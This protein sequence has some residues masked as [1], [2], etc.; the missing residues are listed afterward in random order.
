MMTGNGT[1]PW[2]AG[3]S[4]P[5]G[6]LDI[7]TSKIVCLIASVDP[8]G[9]EHGDIPRATVLGVGHQRSRGVKAGVITDLDDAEEAVRTAVGQAERMAGVT[10]D[11]VY[12]AVSC[13]RLKSR[14]F[15]A[16]ADVEAGVVADGDISRAMAG[17]RAYAERDGRT[18]VHLNRLGFRLDRTA[19]VRDPRGMAARQLSAD[20]HAVTAD[21]A[22]VRN[23]VMA[24][25]RCHLGVAG[26]IA[27]PYAS[28]LAASTVDER[29]LGVTV[30]D[31]G[32][33]TA[34]MASFADGQLI[35]ADAVPV[36][37]NHLTYDIARALQA[38]LA[39]AER[40]KALY[41]TL[42]VASS[43]E[44][45]AFSYPLAGEEEGATNRATRAQL[46]AVIQPRV[47]GTMALIAE[48]LARADMASVATGR[49]VLTGGSSQLVGLGD[50]A[51]AALGRPVRAAGVSQIAGLPAGVS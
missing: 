24:V 12:V 50:F 4:G 40:I 9:P 35:H 13:G 29:R 37:G 43:D 28:A 39:E 8:R 49:V 38:P 26:L 30:I 15:S 42:V 16:N 18:L 21:D 31:L 6:V 11:A 45:E 20:L 36:G 46:R 25:E 1:R 17:G 22:P 3:Q 19:P 33:G 7:G 2:G 10:L 48:R 5:I 14:I 23:L 34:T 47:A 41:G 27:A 44:H 32:G 51:A